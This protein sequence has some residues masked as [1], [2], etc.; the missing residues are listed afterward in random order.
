MPACSVQNS[1]QVRPRESSMRE[2]RTCLRHW[3]RAAEQLPETA[4]KA[5][6]RP[7]QEPRSNC[8]SLSMS[9][10]R[11]DRCGIGGSFVANRGVGGAG[12]HR[13]MRNRAFCRVSLTAY[14]TLLEHTGGGW[15]GGERGWNGEFGVCFVEGRKICGTRNIYEGPRH[16]D[17]EAKRGCSRPSGL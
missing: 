17:D 4:A 13:S 12:S 15:R 3:A 16:G 6:W 2:S 8:F 1:S 11:I 10:F 14:P 9:V 5:F 7:V